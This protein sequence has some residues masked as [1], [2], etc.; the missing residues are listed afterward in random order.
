MP[1]GIYLE[2]DLLQSPAFKEV[3]SAHSIRVLLEFYRRR[4]IYKPKNRRGKHDRPMITNNGEIVLT[5]R[6]AARRLG[7]SQ[8][9]F[10]RCLTELVGLGFLDVA[11]PSCG[12]HRQ[13]T[14]W[15]ISER[16]RRYGQPD[17]RIIK[18]ERIIPPFAKEKKI[19]VITNGGQKP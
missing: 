11:E 6:D 19:S 12:L 8:A 7:I 16:W 17:F 9:T 14:K 15:S 5:Y 10:S 18:R 1:H 3:K 4:K 13:P 2:N